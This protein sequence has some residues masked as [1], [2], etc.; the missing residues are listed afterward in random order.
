MTPENAEKVFVDGPV[1]VFIGKASRERI[2][3]ALD[4]I[5]AMLDEELIRPVGNPT[6][7]IFTFDFLRQTDP[8][9]EPTEPPKGG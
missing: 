9:V 8:S 7:V 2:I 3:V 1:M 6:R 5:G 4:R